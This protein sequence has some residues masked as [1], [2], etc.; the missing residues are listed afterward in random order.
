[1]ANDASQIIDNYL[2]ILIYSKIVIGEE[3]A[4]FFLSKDLELL[5]LF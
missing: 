4:K 1:M 2:I 5:E 3:V